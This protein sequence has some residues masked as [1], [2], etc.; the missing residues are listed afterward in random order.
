MLLHLQESLLDRYS[1]GTVKEFVG[2]TVK[3]FVGETVKEF[4]LN[5]F[6]AHLAVLRPYPSPRGQ[7]TVHTIAVLDG[8]I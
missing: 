4:V 5:V 6:I 3:E 7:P 2:G 8:M 1:G